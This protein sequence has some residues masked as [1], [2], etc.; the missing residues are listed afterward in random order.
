MSH[1]GTGEDCV[2]LNMACCQ[3]IVK[4]GLPW[5]LPK[6]TTDLGEGKYPS[7]ANSIHPD[8][9][10]WGAKMKLRNPHEIRSSEDS[11]KN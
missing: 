6:I 1:F 9:P 11:A 10:K 2:L 4:W 8:P 5:I 7:P 3:G